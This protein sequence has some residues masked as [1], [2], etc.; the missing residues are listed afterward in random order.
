[1][2]NGGILA[3]EE[4]LEPAEEAGLVFLADLDV[5]VVQVY[6]GGDDVDACLFV[7]V[8]VGIVGQL[9]NVGNE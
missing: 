8:G 1:V 3:G 4:V 7:T 9:A 5:D 2:N 6:N